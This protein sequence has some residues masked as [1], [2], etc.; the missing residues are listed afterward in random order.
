MNI[1]KTIGEMAE[2]RVRQAAES[3]A[4]ML[5]AEADQLDRW[6]VQSQTGGWSTNHVDA[7]RTRSSL[8]REK[9]VQM[10]F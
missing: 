8:I 2:A 5:M 3:M 9:L 6:V 4:E 7:M 1:Y 10:G